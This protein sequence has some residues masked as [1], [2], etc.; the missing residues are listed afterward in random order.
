MT[1]TGVGGS[2]GATEGR[3]KGVTLESVGHLV[4]MEVPKLCAEKAIEWLGPE[5]ER[6][7][8]EEETWK[9]E[10]EAKTRL[11]RQVVSEEWKRMAGG[12]P[13][14]GSGKRSSKL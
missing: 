13:R 7:C 3:V 11:E 4:P 2:G 8:T 12:D 6:W 14:A 1:G 10:W 9:K 5:T